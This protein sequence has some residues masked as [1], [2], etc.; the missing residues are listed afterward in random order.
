M[1]TCQMPSAGLHSSWTVLYPL[2]LSMTQPLATFSTTRSL[3]LLLRGLDSCSSGEATMGFLVTILTCLRGVSTA[4]GR[5]P[6]L[7]KPASTAHREL[8]VTCAYILQAVTCA[9]AGGAVQ[10]ARMMM[11]PC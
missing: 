10:K 1:I 7:S 11:E 4:P 6:S 9:W 3:A 8:G 5:G 2:H